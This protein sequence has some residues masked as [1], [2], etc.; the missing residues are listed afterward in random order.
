MFVSDERGLAVSYSVAAGRLA[1]VP[2]SGWPGTLSRAVYAGG[3][4]YLLRV[5][6]LGAAPAVSRLVCVRFTQ[7]TYRDGTMTIGLRWEAIGGAGRLFPALDADIRLAADGDDAS[8]LTLTGSYRP[9]LGALG[10]ELD[11]LIMHTV[12][13]ATIRT[14]LARV[15]VAL[16][17]GPAGSTAPI[18]TW[19]PDTAG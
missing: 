6:A 19:S 13:S 4:E 7:P 8:R 16:E 15:A 10:A 5:G 18:L 3:M 14:L 2:C 11:R 12:A 1:R 9:P 17:D